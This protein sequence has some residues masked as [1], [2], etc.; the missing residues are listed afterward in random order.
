MWSAEPEPKS[1]VPPVHP[2][3]KAPLAGAFAGLAALAAAAAVSLNSLPVRQVDNAI[4][5]RAL[6]LQH[7]PIGH[8]LLAIVHVCDRVPYAVIGA[9]IVSF[10]ILARRRRA[11]VTAGLILSGSVAAAESLKPLLATQ[12]SAPWL[13]QQVDPASWPSGHASAALALALAVVLVAPAGVR[14]PLALAGAAFVVMLAASTLAF[15]GHFPSDLI[16]GYLVTAVCALLA[17]A[18]TRSPSRSTPSEAPTA[19]DA[20]WLYRPPRRF[21]RPAR[22]LDHARAGGTPV[23]IGQGVALP[24]TP[25]Q[26]HRP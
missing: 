10:A 17:L 16:G 8:A 9:C 19:I 7:G 26:V 20:D 6:R 24:D 1:P 12:R 2:G 18:L 4:A 14:R 23:A 13:E 25:S 3:V 5:G 11:A 15:G 21:T 22:G